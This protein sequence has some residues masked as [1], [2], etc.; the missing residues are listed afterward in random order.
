MDT[1]TKPWLTRQ[2]AAEHASVSLRTIDR[3]LA[4]GKLTRYRNKNNRV[5]ISADE[6]ENATDLFMPERRAS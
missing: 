3:M 5:R 1:D 6:L 2:Q 4:E